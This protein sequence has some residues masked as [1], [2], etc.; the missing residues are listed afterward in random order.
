MLRYSLC[1]SH[2]LPGLTTTSWPRPYSETWPVQMLSLSPNSKQWTGRT[3]SIRRK[4]GIIVAVAG[5]ATAFRLPLS[6]RGP[7]FMVRWMSG[8]GSVPILSKRQNTNAKGRIQWLGTGTATVTDSTA[9]SSSPAAPSW[10]PPAA[11]VYCV[12]GARLAA[13][14]G[15]APTSVAI[16][17]VVLLPCWSHPTMVTTSPFACAA[18]KSL[19]FF[20]TERGFA[21]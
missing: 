4:A 7:L 1:A 2:R 17:V 8:S 6:D 20:Q 15:A 3:W 13:P 12:E 9:S 18:S 5:L 19:H 10:T 21:P 14:E 16:A 11:G